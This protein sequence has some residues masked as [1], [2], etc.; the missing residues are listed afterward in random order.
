MDDIITGARTPA[1]ALLQLIAPIT[2][3]LARRKLARETRN[4]L[5]R[6]SDR[7]LDDIGLSRGD[8]QT[9]FGN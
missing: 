8:I 3:R 1:R 9:R 7:Q 6:L 4:A 5:A 2:T